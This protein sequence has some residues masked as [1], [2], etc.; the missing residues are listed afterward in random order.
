MKKLLKILLGLAV[1]AAIALTVFWFARPADVSFEAVR[2]SVPNSEY[3]R[4]A[5]IDGVRLHYQERGVGTPLVL[6]HG[7]TS[8]TYSWKEVFAPL[9]KSFR[10]IAVDLKGFGF[11]GKPDGDYTRRAQ[12]VLVGHLLDHLKIEKAWLGGNSMGGEVALNLA[13]QNPQRVAGLILIDGAGVDVKGSGSLAPGY[14]LVPVVGR[15]LTALALTRD[16]LVR[17]G[18]EKSF[19]DD[20]KVTA[21]RVAYYHRPL[22]TRDGQLAALRARTQ[23]GQFPVEPELSKINAPTLIIWVRTIS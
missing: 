10:V 9:S 8:S 19:Y 22:K 21:E 2:A 11:S 4:F 7:F 1:V 23:S 12:A 14:L 13:F 17:E 16:K 5:D 3:S 15:V 20:A 18:L 6:L